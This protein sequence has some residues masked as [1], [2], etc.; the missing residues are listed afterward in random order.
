[1]YKNRETST[2]LKVNEY[3]KAGLLKDVFKEFNSYQ[4]TKLR[5]LIILSG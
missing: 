5:N 4:L 2:D 3:R 1:M